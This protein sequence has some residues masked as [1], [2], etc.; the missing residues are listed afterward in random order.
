MIAEAIELLLER[1]SELGPLPGI[2]IP[3][4]ESFLP[5]IPIILIVIG[6]AAA[7][8]LWKGFLLS[9]V[10]IC[11]G[12]LLLFYVSRLWGQRF[13]AIIE[14]KFPKSQRFFAY[15]EKRGF[16]P[17]LILFCFPFTPSFPVTV[18]SGMTRIPAFR[19]IVA[20]LLGK[21]FMVFIVSLIGYDLFN[22]YQHPWKLVFSISLFFLIWV[23]GQ[24]LDIS[25]PERS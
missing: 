17:L 3:F 15:I 11:A 2:L 20:L 10:G 24:R 5:F 12:S 4:G 14:K 13:A 6:N 21:A 16:S 23:I 25:R 9:W 1:Y 18:I 7:Y 19:F 8:S 22:I